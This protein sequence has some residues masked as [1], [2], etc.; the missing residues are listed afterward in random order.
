MTILED[1]KPLFSE[2]ERDR[3]HR[4]RSWEHC[5]KFFQSNPHDIDISC[6][7]L[8]F[9]LAS[10]GMYR[11]S[12]FLLQKDYKIHAD[13]IHEILKLKYHSLW[14]VTLESLTDSNRDSQID[15]M[16]SLKDQIATYYDKVR[17]SVTRKENDNPGARDTLVTKILMGTLGCIPAYDC[18][19]IAGIKS[20][21][22][23]YSCLNEKNLRSLLDWCDNNARQLHDAQSWVNAKSKECKYPVMKIVDMY[24]WRKGK[25]SS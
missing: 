21:K 20:E 18:F 8:G 5:Y 22:I 9:Y 4:L 11:G 15:L 24:F 19:F 25:K 14:H 12:S 13:I 16:L 2:I 7:H 10:W 23:P 17:L 1:I 6:L 3:N